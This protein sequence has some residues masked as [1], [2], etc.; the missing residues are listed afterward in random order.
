MTVTTTM[1]RALLAL[2]LAA[3]GGAVHAAGLDL[4]DCRIIN[5]KRAAAEYKAWRVENGKLAGQG[6][7]DAIG[8]RAA[9]ANNRLAC[10]E[11]VLTGNSGWSVTVSS[12]DPKQAGESTTT[13]P[14]GIADIRRHPQAWNTLKE[15]VRLTRQAG[16]FDPGFKSISAQIVLRYAHAL[17]DQLEAAYSDAEGAYEYDCVLKKPFGERNT[18]AACTADRSARAQLLPLVKPARREALDAA[19]HAWAEQLPATPGRKT[20]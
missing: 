2:S 14:A 13:T 7:R 20:N 6:D 18:D 4:S 10:Q 17:P 3:L 16:A 15:A 11:E 9:D 8:M 1:R 19:A 12:S 5:G